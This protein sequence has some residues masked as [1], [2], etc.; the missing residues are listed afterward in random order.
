MGLNDPILLICLKKFTNT[1]VV[2]VYIGILLY[3]IRSYTCK[4][5][6]CIQKKFIICYLDETFLDQRKG[7]QTDP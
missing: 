2:S 4:C 5:Q 1:F 7:T 6:I 3:M